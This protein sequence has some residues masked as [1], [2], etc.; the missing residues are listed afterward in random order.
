MF[1]IENKMAVR[2]PSSVIKVGKQGVFRELTDFEDSNNNNNDNKSGEEHGA[3]PKSKLDVSR[4]A[5]DTGGVSDD[6]TDDDD[7]VSLDIKGSLLVDGV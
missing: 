4:N 3:T 2:K 7:N 6:N 1:K 5:E